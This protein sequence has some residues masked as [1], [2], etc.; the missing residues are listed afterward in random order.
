[1]A[2]NVGIGTIS[3]TFKLEVNSTTGTALGLNSAGAGDLT[4]WYLSGNIKAAVTNSGT[5]WSVSDARLKTNIQ[6]LSE[7]KGLAS[8]MQLNP[9]TFNWA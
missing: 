2:G 3:P 4:D 5:Y 8:I 7:S 9:V 6:S 1:L